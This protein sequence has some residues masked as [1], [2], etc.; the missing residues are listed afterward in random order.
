MK[1]DSRQ[2]GEISDWLQISNHSKVPLGSVHIIKHLLFN[3]VL[4][5]G[6]PAQW[7]VDPP[8]LTLLWPSETIVCIIYRSH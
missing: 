1:R 6:N 7:L 8:F 2:G 4:L 3:Q 5:H